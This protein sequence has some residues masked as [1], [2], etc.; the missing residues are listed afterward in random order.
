MEWLLEDLLGDAGRTGSVR[1]VRLVLRGFVDCSVERRFECDVRGVGPRL[2][3]ASVRP[4]DAVGE[5]SR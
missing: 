2:L 5:G 4:A 3:E 1:T